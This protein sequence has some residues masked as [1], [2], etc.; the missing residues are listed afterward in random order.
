[1]GFG[2]ISNFVDVIETLT[3][4]TLTQ[5]G[6]SGATI[7]EREVQFL[8]NTRR[9]LVLF[10]EPAELFSRILLHD[11]RPLAVFPV[12]RITNFSANITNLD[13][14]EVDP[15]TVL[16]ETVF[17]KFGGSVIA[18]S[19]GFFDTE[20]GLREFVITLN[21]EKTPISAPLVIDVANGDVVDI[22]ILDTADPA[23]V[24]LRI[25][26]TLP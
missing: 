4:V 3:P 19:T 24:E 20:E 1:V 25:F 14:Y 22:V 12:V 8:S 2:E 10:G 23:M 18:L 7:L 26:E 9:T 17:P 13:I 15:G 6:N 11:G 21:G 16:D 5:V